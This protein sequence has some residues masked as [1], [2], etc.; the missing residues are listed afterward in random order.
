MSFPPYPFPPTFSFFSPL[1]L[2]FFKASPFFYSYST[3]LL[4]V[5]VFRHGHNSRCFSPGV[6]GKNT[7]VIS[8]VYI[9]WVFRVFGCFRRSGVTAVR[10]HTDGWMDGSAWVGLGMGHM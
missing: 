4:V 10:A 3:R 7:H 6:L 8:H 1:K 5:H 2:F 9:F